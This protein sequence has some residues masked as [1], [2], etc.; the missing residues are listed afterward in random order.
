MEQFNFKN[1]AAE[2][3]A[4]VALRPDSA[5]A[6]N[7]LATAYFNQRDFNRALETLLEAKRLDPE[8]LQVHYNLGMIYKLQG[9]SADAVTA[10]EF[11]A[12]RDPV[13]PMTHYYLGTVY[14]NLGNLEVAKTHLRKAIGF[15]PENEAAHFGLG[16]ILIRQG[17]V[18]EGRRELEIFRHLKESFPASSAGLQYT[19]MGRYAEAIETFSEPLQPITPETIEE[20]ELQVDG[21]QRRRGCRDAVATEARTSTGLHR[22]RR[23]RRYFRRETIAAP[24]GIGGGVS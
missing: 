14:A 11:V 8:N 16:N 5:P 20:P 23:A 12:A 15:Q 21:Y 6:L 19:E 2:F 13:D 18:E 3:E 10:F 4:L 24:L 22:G 17:E 7:N 9:K 1:A